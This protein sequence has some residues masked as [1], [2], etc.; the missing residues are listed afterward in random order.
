ME[1]MKYG[2]PIIAIPIHVDQPLNARLVEHIGIGVEVV[3]DENGR[4]E[5]KKVATVIKN[6][7][8]EKNGEVREK[9]RKL[10][11]NI[12]KKGE[13]EIDGVDVCFAVEVEGSELS[14]GWFFLRRYLT[15]LIIKVGC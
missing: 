6:V 14:K 8:V 9:A 5:A 1:S 12:E 4:L 10:A 13:E 11:D 15:S 3:R 7:V 2:V